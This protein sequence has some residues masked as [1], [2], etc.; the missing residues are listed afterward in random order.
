MV[1][2][3]LPASDACAIA[4]QALLYTDAPE[5]L[6]AQKQKSLKTSFWK[7]S[8]L[9]RAEGEKCSCQEVMESRP[10]ATRKTSTRWTRAELTPPGGTRG[11]E[12]CLEQG[13]K[14]SQEG[15]STLKWKDGAHLQGHGWT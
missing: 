11:R 3:F 4:P 10:E 15:E 12:G 9:H 14:G 6:E 13:L 5:G 7:P 8:S 1:E 2:S